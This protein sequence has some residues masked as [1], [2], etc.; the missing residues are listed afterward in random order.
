MK[1]Q[2]PP[3]KSNPN[4][5]CL[6]I[7]LGENHGRT[8]HFYFALTVRKM[9]LHYTSVTIHDVRPVPSSRIGPIHGNPERRTP[10]ATPP[11]AELVVCND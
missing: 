8:G 2:K 6:P 7:T 1:K 11:F 5:M 10:R 9:S 4:T 3:T